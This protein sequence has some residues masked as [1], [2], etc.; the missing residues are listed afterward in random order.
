MIL[1]DFPSLI[2]FL[3]KKKRLVAGLKLSIQQ[4]GN[5]SKT[6]A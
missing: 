1:E 5:F 6:P 2:A 4:N 3:A